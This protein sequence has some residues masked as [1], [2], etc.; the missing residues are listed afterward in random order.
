M[1]LVGVQFTAAICTVVLSFLGQRYFTGK[2]VLA[3]PSVLFA[4][5]IYAIAYVGFRYRFGVFQMENELKE[6][7]IP[8]YKEA[9]DSSLFNIIVEK[10]EKEMVFLQPGLSVVDLAKSIG[11][12]RTYVSN[13]INT[14]SGKSFALFVNT[15]RVEYAKK[16]MEKDGKLSIA[17]VAEM[18][19]FASEESFRRNFRNITGKSPSDWTGPVRL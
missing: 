7:I 13:S 1:I 8:T 10:M 2:S 11:S 15:Y 19:G 14:H 16:I 4:A 9:E 18:S 5:T 12:N 17:Q 3:V 6:D